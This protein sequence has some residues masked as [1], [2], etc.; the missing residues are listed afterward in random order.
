MPAHYQVLRPHDVRVSEAHDAF[1]SDVRTGLSQTP[2]SLPSK[3]FYDRAGSRLFQQ[4]TDLPEYY[5]TQCESEI[6]ENKK[7]EITALIRGTQF[8]LVE[9]GAGDGRKTKILL[10]HF[11]KEEL[12]FRYVPIDICE[13]A[14]EGLIVG[15]N[16]HSPHLSIEGL[17]GDYCDGL[18][19]LS[20]MNGHRNVVLF[21]GSSI[22]NFSHAEAREFLYGLWN[23]LENGDYLLI[24]FDLKKDIH[25]LERAYNDSQ[26][27]TARFNLNLLHRINRELDG[28][29]DVDQFQHYS[30]Y[31]AVAGAMESYLISRQEQVVDIAA[32]NQSFA[33]EAWEPV[34]TEYSYKYLES[35]IASLA[36]ETGFVIKAQLMDTKGYF[37]N[38]VWQVSKGSGEH[39]RVKGSLN[40]SYETQRSPR[41]QRFA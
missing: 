5:L 20:T 30:T 19:W 36:E 3:Y 12:D 29:F 13:A 1:A 11:L 10:G 14:V 7:G 24:G 27:V 21:L 9:L 39:S 8:N 4:I 2:K 34:H 25:L 38:S 15:L 31:N 41:L 40:T 6:F 17:V 18:R 23:A 32:L 22:G 16:T 33:F 26:K 28:N 35:D 37:V